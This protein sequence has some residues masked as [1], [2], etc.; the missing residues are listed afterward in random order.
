MGR[1]KGEGS[2]RK[3]IWFLIG[4]IAAL[5]TIFMASCTISPLEASNSEL[6]S[7]RYNPMYV[8]CIEE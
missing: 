5:S 6:G 3:Y 4:Y 8:V 7:S 2:M 1:S